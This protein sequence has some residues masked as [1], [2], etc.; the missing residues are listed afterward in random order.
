[1]A[2]ELKKI[3]NSETKKL[4]TIAETGEKKDAKK[5]E[6]EKKVVENRNAR[7]RERERERK[8]DTEDVLESS[9]HH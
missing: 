2:G 5:A 1:M 9:H 7:D 8:K 6:E 4:T 3:N